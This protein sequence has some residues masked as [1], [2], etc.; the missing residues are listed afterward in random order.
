MQESNSRT[1]QGSKAL[2]EEML[3]GSAM[4][5][6]DEEDEEM[7]EEEYEDEGETEDRLLTLHVQPKPKEGDPQKHLQL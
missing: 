4:V 6:I 2:S 7:E 3:E 5:E 1:I